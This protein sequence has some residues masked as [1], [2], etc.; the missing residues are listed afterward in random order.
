MWLC[1]AAA[2]VMGQVSATWADPS[3]RDAEVRPLDLRG[4]K[5]LEAVEVGLA[6]RQANVTAGQL[7]RVTNPLAD[8]GSPV[9]ASASGTSGGWVQMLIRKANRDARE[10]DVVTLNLRTGKYKV[11]DPIKGYG[12]AYTAWSG[13][14]LYWTTW[15]P[16]GMHEYDPVSDT[17]RDLGF[18]FHN[19]DL[20]G[21][22]MSVSPDG[23]ISMG[24]GGVS[25]VSM[26][27]PATDKLTMIGIL[28]EKH[29]WVYS[30]GS[31]NDY[32][33]AALRGKAP[34]EL[35]VIDKKTLERRTIA[36]VPVKG[37]MDVGGTRVWMSEDF[38]GGAERKTY[39][40]RGREMTLFNP[41]EASASAAPAKP[42]APKP[43]KPKVLIDETPL[44]RGS[45]ELLIHYQDPDDLSQWK[46]TS[47]PA[48]LYTESTLA[49]AALPDGTVA[50]MGG[51]YGPATLYDP[52]TDVT[53]QAPFDPVS[54][55]CLV[56]VGSVLYGSGYPSTVTMRWDTAAPITSPDELP[57]RSGVSFESKS[58]NPRSLGAWPQSPTS[59]G[60]MGV[61]IFVGAD[62]CIYIATARHRH[63]SG[64]D[65]V[66]YDP[67]TEQKGEIDDKGLLD[68]HNIGWAS[69]L[70][71]GRRLIV[72][73]SLHANGQLTSP[74]PTEAAL[75][76]ADLSGRS[77]EAQPHHPLPGAKAYTGIVEV[78]PN[79]VVGLAPADDQK[80]TWVYRYNLAERKLEKVARYAGLIHGT[81]GT[82]GLPAKGM[83][84][85]LGPGRD[86]HRR[87][88][89]GM[90]AG[91]D[92]SMLMTIDPATLDITR[93][94]TIAGGHIRFAFTS[95]ATHICGAPRIRRLMVGQ[96]GDQGK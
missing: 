43:V 48:P 76:V 22:R 24:G 23:V 40:L 70:D 85:V 96:S 78:A 18:P 8:A 60:H 6:G 89:T 64:F 86:A 68:H 26:Y 77:Y 88:W 91:A 4:V 41:A 35:V 84:F 19:H 39:D 15:I 55:R 38:S 47:L 10:F 12:Q 50:A 20:G 51:P 7:F 93:L 27:D 11:H 36:T 73:T 1:M 16:G 45:D 13:G 34:W 31:D 67:A 75:F 25:E 5:A 37:Y 87:I 56:A 32:I 82:T 28:S 83:D 90:G 58:A 49:I 53:V 80:S 81:D 74:V 54:G 65:V 17:I 52:A 69:P 9:E 33:Y 92:Q 72:A 29:A 44:L 59:G 71:G 14:K 42:A 63:G 79:V 57:D 66:W 30:I 94:G 95:D 61:R 3:W 46:Q 62:Q 2:V 21:Y